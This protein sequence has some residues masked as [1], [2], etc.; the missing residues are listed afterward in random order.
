MCYSFGLVSSR[1]QNFNLKDPSNI[2]E[3]FCKVLTLFVAGV[4]RLKQRRAVKSPYVITNIC[5]AFNFLL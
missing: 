2:D 4:Q 1:D 5:R 3:H